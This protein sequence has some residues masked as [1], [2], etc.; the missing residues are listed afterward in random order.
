MA[1]RL[2]GEAWYLR[3]SVNGTVK[4]MA[5]GVYGGEANRKRATRAHDLMLKKVAVARADRKAEQQLGIAP[6]AAPT[7]V[8][9]VAEWTATYLTTYTP[10]KAESTQARD[11]YILAQW[12][13][14]PARVEGRAV[15]FGSLRLDA[16]KQMHCLAGIAHREASPTGQADRKVRTTLTAGTVQRERRLLQAVFERAVENDLIAKN[17]FRGIAA[18]RD[19]T[20]HDR[21]LTVEDEVKLLAVMAAERPDAT[22][23][24]VTTHPRYVR[25]ITFLLETGLRID[26]LLN[27]QFRDRGASVRVVG[28]GGKERVVRLTAKARQTLDDQWADT[29]SGESVRPTGGGP[30]WQNEQRFRAVMSVACVR[31]KI[32]HLSPH[33]LRHTFGHRFLVRGG[34]IKALSLFLGHASVAVTDKHYSYLSN[35]NVGDIHPTATR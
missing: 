26:E 5:L 27:D 30:W 28:K 32:G 19:V 25:F 22:G 34:N 2:A 23:R 15:T 11:R 17:P 9:T 13:A 29:G 4:D 33:D 21:I 6:K 3:C 31:A 16:V 18:K 10:H 35:Q 12:E 7:A 20:R 14:V 1:L 24:A 8:P